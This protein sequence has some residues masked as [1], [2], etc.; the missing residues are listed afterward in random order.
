MVRLFVGMA[1][2]RYYEASLQVPA[3]DLPD[4]YTLAR[5]R[6]EITRHG[7]M[8][9]FKIGPVEGGDGETVTVLLSSGTAAKVINVLEMILVNLGR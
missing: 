8:I 9:G 3:A 1:D 6:F 2:Q 4:D 5:R 7:G